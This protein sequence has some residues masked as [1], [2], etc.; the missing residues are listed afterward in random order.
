MKHRHY[1]FYIYRATSVALITYY[2]L[3]SLPAPANQA[4]NVVIIE[5]E[6]ALKPNTFQLQ[7]A[8]SHLPHLR[9]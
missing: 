9:R 3:K 7:F 2:I 6:G 1:S 4:H 8:C 5:E